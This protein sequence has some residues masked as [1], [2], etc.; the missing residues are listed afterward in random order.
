L[1]C[2]KTLILNED[3]RE[4]IDMDANVVPP[5]NGPFNLE[6]AA[7]AVRDFAANLI[8]HPRFTTGLSLI[9]EFAAVGIVNE[10]APCMLMRGPAGVGKTELVRQHLRENPPTID[11]DTDQVP[12]VFLQTPAE[13]TLKSLAEALLVELGDPAP[14]RGSQVEKT[15]RVKHYIKDLRVRLIILDEVQHLTGRRT[16]RVLIGAANWLKQLLNEGG[17]PILL[18]GTDEA[19][20]VLRRDQQLARRCFAHHRL[21]PFRWEVQSEREEFLQLV[22]IYDGM[23]PTAERQTLLGDEMGFRLH[24]ATLGR[25]GRLSLLLQKAL[26]KALL[27]GRPAIE[28]H[29]LRLAYDEWA[30]LHE[31]TGSAN[32]ESLPQLNPF[33]ARAA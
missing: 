19:D 2:G 29:H 10:Q 24:L 7:S 14:Q 4:G 15:Q 16:D 32:Q 31:L 26:L 18:V 28:E 5:H 12:V 30:V 11:G 3:T 6:A 13:V 21:E 20:M 1:A 9:E 33:R 17:C 25:L 27:E 8:F 23:L 22:S